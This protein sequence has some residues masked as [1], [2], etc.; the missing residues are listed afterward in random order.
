MYR[1]EVCRGS[2]RRGEPLLRHVLYRRKPVVRVLAGKTVRQERKEIAREIACCAGC[3]ALLR[4]GVPLA[5]IQRK[6]EGPSSV[7]DLSPPVPA[8]PVIVPNAPIRVGTPA[9][10]FAQPKLSSKRKSK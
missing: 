6:H 5:E 9:K 10:L 3:F 2:S 1:C 7:E 8:P 4:E